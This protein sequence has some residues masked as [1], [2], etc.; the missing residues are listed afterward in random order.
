[1][2]VIGGKRHIVVDANG[3]LLSATVHEANIQDRGGT[4]QVL[5]KVAEKY[6]DL[7]LIWVGGGY[8]GRLVQWANKKT[9][10]SKSKQRKDRVT[11]KDL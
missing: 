2:A 8:A 1:M 5:T 7:K 6:P 4:V 11:R 10:H 3:L 9:C